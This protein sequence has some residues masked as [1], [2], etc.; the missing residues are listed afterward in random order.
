MG[1]A[2]TAIALDEQ[3]ACCAVKIAAGS[4][5]PQAMA[6]WSSSAIR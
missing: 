5:R 6:C 2:R 4:L 3:D 1:E